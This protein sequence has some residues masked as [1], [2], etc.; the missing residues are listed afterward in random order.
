MNCLDNGSLYLIKIEEFYRRVSF[1]RFD[2]C[3][4]FIEMPVQIPKK[5][6]EQYKYFVLNNII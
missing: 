6:N 4:M 2:L 1:M 3:E 5:K